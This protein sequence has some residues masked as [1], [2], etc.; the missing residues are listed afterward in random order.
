[1]N[2]LRIFGAS[3]LLVLAACASTASGTVLE[4]D[5]RIDLVTEQDFSWSPL[6]IPA[7]DGPIAAF[8]A[9]NSARQ[10]VLVNKRDAFS[11]G[12]L[13]QIEA[14]TLIIAQEESTDGEAPDAAAL[15]A[16]REK[17]LAELTPEE[18][19]AY[20]REA[21]AMKTF[22]KEFAIEIGKAGLAY[23]GT[24]VIRD[25][26]A[27]SSTIDAAK[28]LGGLQAIQAARQLGKAKDMIEAAQE[29]DALIKYMENNLRLEEAVTNN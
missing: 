20:D 16:A 3:V 29:I 18:R 8:C 23:V 6:G 21:S 26:L 11:Y 5:E 22:A 9:Y 2:P 19:A 15:N 24:E 28:A 25:L 13:K 4:I 12:A 1:M 14:R 7:V 10:Q 27:D 17:A